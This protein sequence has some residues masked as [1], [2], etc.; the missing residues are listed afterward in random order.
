[1]ASQMIL[2]LFSYPVGHHAAAWRHPLG[3]ADRTL[4][5]DFYLDIAKT[6][7]RGFSTLFSL[8][9]GQAASCSIPPVN[10]PRFSSQSLCSLHFPP[11]QSTLA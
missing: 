11:R 8:P 4:D 10:T 2:N 7:E 9:I 3:Q 1:M 5:I 6:A